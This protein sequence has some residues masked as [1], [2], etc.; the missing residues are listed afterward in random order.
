MKKLLILLLTL[1]GVSLLADSGLSSD[2]PN[3]LTLTDPEIDSEENV[4]IYETSDGEQYEVRKLEN[5]PQI[6]ASDAHEHFT[7]DN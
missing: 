6:S 5:L 2:Y 4:A 3:T 7:G 1:T